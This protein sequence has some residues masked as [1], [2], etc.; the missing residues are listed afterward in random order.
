MDQRVAAGFMTRV[1]DHADDAGVVLGGMPGPEK[2]GGSLMLG[3][4]LQQSRRAFLHAFI[5]IGK[6]ADVGFH[7]D[8]EYHIK[9][10]SHKTSPML[11]ITLRFAIN[12][13]RKSGKANRRRRKMLILT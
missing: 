9:A 1:A 6:T 13:I 2:G 5:I 11:I 10:A 7:V 4:Q 3:H 12:I 8:S